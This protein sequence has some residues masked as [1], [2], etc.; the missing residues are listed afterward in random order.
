MISKRNIEDRN[1]SAIRHG[2]KSV[3]HDL[4]LQFWGSNHVTVAHL[5]AVSLAIF[6]RSEH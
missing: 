2:P 1:A 3:A 6:A 5:N 4:G